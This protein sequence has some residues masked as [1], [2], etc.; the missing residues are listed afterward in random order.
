MFVHSIIIVNHVIC[1]H[2][3]HSQPYMLCAEMYRT[4]KHVMLFSEK[5]STA[6]Y[7]FFLDLTAYAHKIAH[8]N[9]TR[10]SCRVIVHMRAKEMNAVQ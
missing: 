3:Q 10:K 1:W 4:V 2:V 9:D 5:Y 7:V 6:Q 8:K